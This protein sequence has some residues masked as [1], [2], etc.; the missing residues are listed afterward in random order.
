MAA[1]Q[2]ASAVGFCE[3]SLAQL[4]IRSEQREWCGQD[5][6]ASAEALS[7]SCYWIDWRWRNYGEGQWLWDGARPANTCDIRR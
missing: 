6:F 2:N 4:V 3:L 1:R 5:A 7:W